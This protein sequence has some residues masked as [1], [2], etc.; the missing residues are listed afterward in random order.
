MT[1]KGA[2]AGALLLASVGLI[3]TALG[4]IGISPTQT[5]HHQGDIPAN[6]ECQK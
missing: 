3:F 5:A 6:I 4:L 1:D 2:N